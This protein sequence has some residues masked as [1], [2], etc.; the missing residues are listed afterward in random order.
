MGFAS[1][2]PRAHQLHTLLASVTPAS[3]SDRNVEPLSS[4]GLRLLVPQQQPT[5]RLKAVRPHPHLL[6][7]LSS[8][9][10]HTYTPLQ[11]YSP[12]LLAQNSPMSSLGNGIP[13]GVNSHLRRRTEAATMSA[14]SLPLRLPFE[15]PN[16]Y[17]N[18]PP[19]HGTPSDEAL[20]FGSSPMLTSSAFSPDLA[21]FNNI[22]PSSYF[23]GY[24][25]PGWPTGL[26]VYQHSS[27]VDR[28][29]NAMEGVGLTTGSPIVTNH[30][31]SGTS[32]DTS[33]MPAT[34]ADDPP[35]D[36]DFPSGLKNFPSASAAGSALFPD[37]AD[38]SDPST[39]IAYPGQPPSRRQPLAVDTTGA[40]TYS[41]NP[42]DVSVA[43]PASSP[44]FTSA[45]APYTAPAHFQRTLASPT[46][47][48]SYSVF[49]S[50]GN[51]FPLGQVDE[52]SIGQSGALL[53]QSTYSSSLHSALSV[54]PGGAQTDRWNHSNALLPSDTPDYLAPPPSSAPAEYPDSTFQFFN[55]NPLS[56]LHEDRPLQTP[57]PLPPTSISP[58]M[59]TTAGME[60]P[61]APPS[62]GPCR[63]MRVRPNP[64]PYQSSTLLP[65]IQRLSDTTP[66]LMRTVLESRMDELAHSP[67][68]RNTKE[69]ET[70]LQEILT[71]FADMIVKFGEHP[72]GSSP[73]KSK[74]GAR[75]RQTRSNQNKPGSFVCFYC[76]IDITSKQ[77]LFKHLKSVHLRL[78]S[79]QC[80]LCGASLA[81]DLS[82][83]K[84][85]C[86]KTC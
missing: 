45:I 59:L 6:P 69:D 51:D 8:F 48:H 44:A 54:H 84:R 74:N 18:T 11:Q 38:G 36:F 75:A 80:D 65:P 23:A 49:G 37:G 46:S 43:A 61:S 77:N 79:V 82:R 50:T 39:W 21:I 58:Q 4:Q 73:C 64:S 9:R 70:Y 52:Y 22:S 40:T 53:S 66:N 57:D 55:R 25:S 20:R 1:H 34:P 14:V 41:S 31:G 16:K 3:T 76:S 68:A 19:V 7:T 35:L 83:H 56:P 33:S 42:S 29:T 13:H 81:G 10:P 17:F 30:S 24:Y 15:G 2:P 5:L 60:P 62:S 78:K 12:L 28:V 72:C 71:R 63:P 67:K 26:N 27:D 86:Q 85:T 32:Q 47:A